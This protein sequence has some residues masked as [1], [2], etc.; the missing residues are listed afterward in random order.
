M[1]AKDTVPEPQSDTTKRS[2]LVEWIKSHQVAAFFLVT[3][4]YSYLIGLPLV[5]TSLGWVPYH[6]P[7]LLA[8]ANQLLAAWG[9]TLTA[10][11][12]TG[13]ISGKAGLKE[14]LSRVVRWRVGVQWYAFVLLLYGVVVSI[15][16]GLDV[17]LGGKV[18]GTIQ[19]TPWYSVPLTFAIDFPL[20]LFVGGPLAEEL[21][22]RGFALPRLLK[23]HNAF[24]SALFIGVIWA[25]WHLP[26][27]WIPGSGSGSGL[28]DFVWFFFQLTAW[29]VLLAWVYINTRGSLL[30]CILFHAAGNT[31][32]SGVLEVPGSSRANIFTDVLLWV[33]V[34]IVLLVFGSAHLSRTQDTEAKSGSERKIISHSSQR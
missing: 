11:F 33:V 7:P 6:M 4:G 12:L 18:P 27:F 34:I 26:L 31:W 29:G 9:P 28:S 23:S 16:L 15:A 30:L 2:P 17:L 13:L 24:F 1:I 21:G 8:L 10:L 25:F 32:T 5:A 20:F 22:W 14:L 3:F 19:L